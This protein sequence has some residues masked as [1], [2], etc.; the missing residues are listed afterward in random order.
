MDMNQLTAKA[1]ALGY[2]FERGSGRS[3]AYY[4]LKDPDDRIVLGEGFTASPKKI[5]KFLDDHVKHKAEAL[6]L[7]LSIKKIADSFDELSSGEARAVQREATTGYKLDA[8]EVIVDKGRAGEDREQRMQRA[9]RGGDTVE[10]VTVLGHD[11]TATLPEVIDYLNDRAADV[12]LDDTEVESGS[13]RKSAPTKTELAR[14]LKD[15]PNAEPIRALD[16]PARPGLEQ[17]RRQQAIDD[18]LSL[19]NSPTRWAPLPLAEKRRL[20]GN[21][22]ILLAE[23]RRANDAKHHVQKKPLTWAELER[24]EKERKNRAHRDADHLFNRTNIKSLFDWKADDHNEAIN[25][26]Q[27]PAKARQEMIRSGNKYWLSAHTPEKG[28]PIFTTPQA[29]ATA[30]QVTKKKSRVPA[31]DLPRRRT[32]LRLAGAFRDARDRK[33]QIGAGRLLSEAKP[34][35]GHGGWVAWLTTLGLSERTARHWMGLAI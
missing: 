26:R 16:T 4:Q 5:D 29:P 25:N 28:T 6:G 32:L 35:V 10:W 22:Q 17:Q 2:S 30:P 34:L 18:L 23:D 15:H 19:M 27:D 7:R 13:K 21:L 31:A 11:H 3:A 33:D 20:N 8:K 12:G 24:L 9:Q 1:D 14:A